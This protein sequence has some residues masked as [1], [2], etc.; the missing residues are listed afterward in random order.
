MNCALRHRH[1]MSVENDL[2]FTRHSVFDGSATVVVKF[3]LL[4]STIVALQNDRSDSSFCRFR[5]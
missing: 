3:N 4:T 1:T 5:V 2:V